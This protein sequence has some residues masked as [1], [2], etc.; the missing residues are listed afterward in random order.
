MQYLPILRQYEKIK[1]GFATEIVNMT[2]RGQAYRHSM[3]LV[4]RQVL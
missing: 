2:I 4:R 1:S 3:F